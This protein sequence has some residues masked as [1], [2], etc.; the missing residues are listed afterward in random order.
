MTLP[1]RAEAIWRVARNELFDSIRSRRVMVLGLLYVAGSA[2][3]TALFISVLQKIER[4]LAESLGLAVA[5]D[6][7]SVTATLWKSD[8]FRRMATGLA[9]DKALAAR[10]LAIPP[11]GI[12]Y[13]WLSFAFAPALVMLT[14]ATRI[15]EEVWSG[16]AR[17]ALFRVGRLEWVLGKFAG[18]A[19]QLVP[20]LLLSGAAAWLT[21]LLRMQA[22]EPAATARAVTVFALQA[23]L[24]AMAFLGLAT[25]ISQICAVPNLALAF[26]FVSLIA[27]QV[28][29]AVSHHLTSHYAA[30][31]WRRVWDAVHA[32]TPGGHRTDFW[33]G[34]AA[35]TIPATVFLLALG[36]CYLLAGYAAFSRRDL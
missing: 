16:S 17:F 1:P 19:A 5:S 32:L 30:P 10:L 3:A 7:G 4:Q 31:A 14:S 22:F 29:T 21:G 24:Y 11:L 36:L 35:H 33:W 15:S 13:G 34:D 23:W 27:L 18:Q 12:F 8:A 20:A 28:L 2:A 6:A 25:A 26:G 9:G